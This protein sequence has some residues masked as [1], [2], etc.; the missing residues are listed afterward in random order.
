MVFQ[1]NSL[2][3]KRRLT[4][5][6]IAALILCTSIYLMIKVIERNER[7][8]QMDVKKFLHSQNNRTISGVKTGKPCK[9]AIL[10]I[11]GAPGSWT[12]WAKYLADEDLKEKFMMIAIDRPGYGGS[13][14]SKPLTS[15]KEQAKLILNAALREHNGPFLVV[16]H[17]YAGPIQIQMSIDF[18][19][20]IKAHIKLAGAIDPK[21][22]K[23]R[24]YHILG[25]LF[26]IRPLLPRE[27]KIANTEMLGL[28]SEL[29]KQTAD[30]SK[31]KTPTIIIQGESDWLIPKGN[32]K[33]AREKLTSSENLE[34]IELKD[35]GHFIPWKEYGLVKKQILKFAT[36]SQCET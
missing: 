20:K 11:H 15:I 2:L 13:D 19:E 27:L 33:Y 26:F 23:E 16:G 34:I 30:L 9:P 24:F 17:S 6:L 29:T 4:I 35:Q 28:Q 22:H 18:P 7:I 36:K 10:F 32:A 3:K 5:I 25:D 8:D 21:L 1:I 31:I 14:F 12:A